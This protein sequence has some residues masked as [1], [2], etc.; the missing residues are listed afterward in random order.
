MPA[1]GPVGLD[2]RI[3]LPSPYVNAV[4]IVTIGKGCAGMGL[5]GLMLA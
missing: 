4:C 1:L 3:D 5:I 2:A